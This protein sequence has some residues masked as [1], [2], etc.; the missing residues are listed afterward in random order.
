LQAGLCYNF[1]V[2]N[3]IPPRTKKPTENEAI[4]KVLENIATLQ[5]TLLS[6]TVSSIESKSGNILTAIGV[7]LPI[8]LAVFASGKTPITQ[9]NGYYYIALGLLI[10][11]IVLNIKVLE[12][13]MFKINPD[14]QLFYQ[15]NLMR[16]NNVMREAALKSMKNAL[17]YD[18]ESV[19]FKSRFFN[20][21]LYSFVLSIIFLII[22]TIVQNH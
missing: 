19:N 18:M 21:S 5:Y 11:T 12:N 15:Y 17:N 2:S 16:D 3:Q 1:Q 4:Y 20:L 14:I 8:V 6:D 22:G 7:F 10:V 9:L 13:R